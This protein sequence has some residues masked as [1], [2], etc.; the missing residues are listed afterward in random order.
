WEG[1]GTLRLWDVE[2]GRELRKMLGIPLGIHGVAFSPDGRLALV[3]GRDP[4]VQLWDLEKGERLNRLEGHT[5]TVTHA[6]FTP[7]GRR[8]LS[9]GGDKT[10]RLWRLPV[11]EAESGAVPKPLGKDTRTSVQDRKAVPTS[12]LLAG[13]GTEPVGEIA[14]FQSPRDLIGGALLL[15]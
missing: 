11:P 3:C 7:D 13:A 15:P 6:V 10:L 8:A 5:D 14:R 1:D 9:G 12:E 2:T 4:D